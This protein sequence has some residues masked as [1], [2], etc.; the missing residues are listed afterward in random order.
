V[1]DLEPEIRQIESCELLILQFPLCWFGLPAILKGW[2]DR[3]LAAGRTY[4]QGALYEKGKFGSKR[5]LLSLP[6]VGPKR[7]TPRPVF[8]ATSS[9][10][11]VLFRVECRNFWAST[12]SRQKSTLAQAA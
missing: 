2:F 5:A 10:S 3:V 9:V 11:C 6:R 1:Q 7:D 8:M 12:F 4:G